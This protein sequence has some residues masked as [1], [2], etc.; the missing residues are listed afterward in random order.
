V[1]LSPEEEEEEKKGLGR[2]PSRY[3]SPVVV[4]RM[5]VKIRS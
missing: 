3:V 1:E 4:A 2:A 5:A